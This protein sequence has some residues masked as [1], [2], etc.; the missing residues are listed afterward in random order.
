[1]EKFLIKIVI[2]VGIILALLAV[3]GGTDLVYSAFAAPSTRST[4]PIT[5]QNQDP[6]DHSVA[7]Q[8]SLG[9]FQSAQLAINYLD[10]ASNFSVRTDCYLCHGAASSVF[11]TIANAENSQSF[12]LQRHI[13]LTIECAGCHTQKTGQ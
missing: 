6:L 11:S 2:S 12:W 7:Y 4:S 9:Y 13:G 10:G 5:G 1:V 8:S 3:T